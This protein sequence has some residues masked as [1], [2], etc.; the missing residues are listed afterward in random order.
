MVDIV[1]SPTNDNTMIK[2][3]NIK[4]LVVAVVCEL[5]YV[6][7]GGSLLDFGIGVQRRKTRLELFDLDLQHFGGGRLYNGDEIRKQWVNFEKIVNILS[8]LASGM[9]GL[10]HSN[11]VLF[12]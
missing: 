3:V 4:V 10:Y 11:I 9:V 7:K 8:Y 2:I 1:D 5:G 12:H 6:D